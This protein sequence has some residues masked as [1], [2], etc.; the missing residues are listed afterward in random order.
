MRIMR[1]AVLVGALVSVVGCGTEPFVLL[2]DEATQAVDESQYELLARFAHISDAHIIDEESPGRL[3]VF[4]RLV[5][6]AWRPQEAYSLQLLDGMIRTV[7]KIHVAQTP[8]DFLIH[9]GDATDNAQINEYQWFVTVMD[10]GTVNPLTGPDDRD[11]I[12]VPDPTLDPHH[13]FVAQ[14]LYRHGVHGRDATIPWY[15][16][17]GNHDLFAEGVFPIVTNIYGDRTSPLPLS[18]RIGLFAPVILNPTGGL[19]WGAITPAHPG[20][21]PEVVLPEAIEP[22]PD[23]RFATAREFVEVHAA[24][25]TEPVGHGFDPTSPGALW[26]SVS[27]KPGLRLIGL[28]TSDPFLQI[29]TEVY[30]EGAIS[31]AQIEFLKAELE[32]AQKRGD[33]VIVATH[34]PSDA[35]AIGNG[36]SVSPK[37]FRDILNGFPCVALHIAG[38]WH[39][40]LAIDRGGYVELITGA[41]IDAPQTGRIVSIWKKRDTNSAVSPATVELRYRSFSHLDTIEPPDDRDAALFDDPL[42]GMR[43]VAFRLA[44][45]GLQP[46]TK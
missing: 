44:T 27:P 36:S 45:G 34:H 9:T 10:G 3:T 35:I 20:P 16:I 21:P 46:V 18:N 30:S 38:H 33:V 17:A 37:S 14:G 24:S 12:E 41:I 23:R 42:R 25:V 29:P 19:A 32:A 39:T 40:N 11:A 43:E 15:T 4:A 8:I 2:P 26:Y 28:N 22:N 7:N 6:T 5:S 31:F 1:H 13:S